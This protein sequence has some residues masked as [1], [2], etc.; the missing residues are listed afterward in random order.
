MKYLHLI[1]SYI[2]P[3]IKPQSTQYITS[4]KMSQKSHAHFVITDILRY[5]ANHRSDMELW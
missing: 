4:S 5:V 1:N 3:Y 2:N